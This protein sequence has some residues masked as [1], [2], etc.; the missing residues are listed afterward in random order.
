MPYNLVVDGFHTKKLCSRLSSSEVRFYTENGRF[1]FLNPF[2]GFRGNVRYL[3]SLVDFLLVLIELFSLGITTEVLR[4]NIDKNR[5]FRYSLQP[6]I[7]GRSGLPH[8]S[9]SLS[10]KLG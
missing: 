5:R 2:G 1:A 6:K 4:A 10:A 9:F 7:S 3:S 8:Q